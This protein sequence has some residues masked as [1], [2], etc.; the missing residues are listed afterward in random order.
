MCR[1]YVQYGYVPVDPSPGPAPPSPRP[2]ASTAVTVTV[3]PTRVSDPRYP[4]GARGGAG[5]NRAGPFFVTTIVVRLR[6]LVQSDYVTQPLFIGVVFTHPRRDTATFRTALAMLL[7]V[8]PRMAEVSPPVREWSLFARLTRALT[9]RPP[10]QIPAVVIDG[11][12]ALAHALHDMMPRTHIM[13]DYR[14]WKDNVLHQIGSDDRHRLYA[15]H[16]QKLVDARTFDEFDMLAAQAGLTMP[17]SLWRYLNHGA[18]RAERSALQR[19]RGM[20]SR[21]HTSTGMCVCLCAC[22]GECA[23]ACVHARET[24]PRVRAH[25]HRGPHRQ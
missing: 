4:A 20:P 3:A 22:M 7:S 14:H 21:G 8:E 1:H 19:L 15:R 23:Y 17:P 9:H 18:G 10:P 13:E 5:R 2:R 6:E 25:S 12:A 16:V 11:D 24:C